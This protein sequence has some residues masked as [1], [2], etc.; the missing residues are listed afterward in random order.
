MARARVYQTLEFTDEFFETFGRFGKSDQSRFR[1]AMRL[2][3]TDE[4]HRGAGGL[5]LPD[6]VRGKKWM[7]RRNAPRDFL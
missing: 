5:N 4:K 2:L 1:R 7:R 3:D 6:I